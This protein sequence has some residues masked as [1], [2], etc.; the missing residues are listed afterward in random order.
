MTKTLSGKMKGPHSEI[1]PRRSKRMYSPSSAG[2]DP[3]AIRRA[4]EASLRNAGADGLTR[5]PLYHSAQ[6]LRELP[7]GFCAL[8]R[9]FTE[10]Y[11]YYEEH[12]REEIGSVQ[13]DV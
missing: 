10:K 12:E 13:D 6:F 5:G 4:T 3:E 2:F 9:L 11:N 7:R 1:M 8:G